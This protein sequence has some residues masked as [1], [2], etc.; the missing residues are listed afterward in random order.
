MLYGVVKYTIIHSW[1]FT[2]DGGKMVNAF[3]LHYYAVLAER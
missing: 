2:S 3:L 1:W